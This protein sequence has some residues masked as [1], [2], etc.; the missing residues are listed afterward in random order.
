MTVAR[1][2]LV[3]PARL[4]D[5]APA[6]RPADRGHRRSRAAVALRARARRAAP[7]RGGAERRPRP[8][9][10]PVVVSSRT[11]EPERDRRDRRAVGGRRAGHRRADS[12]IRRAATRLQ[13]VLL[14]AAAE[15]CRRLARSSPVV[16]E[17]RRDARGGVRSE[18]RRPLSVVGAGGRSAQARA[19]G[20]PRY[21]HAGSAHPGGAAPDDGVHRAARAGVVPDRPVPAASARGVPAP[22]G[23]PAP[24]VVS[25]SFRSSRTFTVS[26]RLRGLQ[27]F[28][29]LEGAKR[30]AGRV[31]PRRRG[32]R[33]RGHAG[34]P[35]HRIGRRRTGADDRRAACSRRH[36]AAGECDRSARESN[37]P[38]RRLAW[39]RHRACTS[40]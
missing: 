11:G 4:P 13:C 17:P 23:P 16:P 6:G 18:V 5:R 31:A 2:A 20:H 37:G 27:A 8:R 32:R 30:R 3:L 25:R 9:P 22:G 28:Q 12:R 21:R 39:N 34:S 26:R 7:S 36:C 29:V 33:G 24:D 14:R 15:H 19:A 35:G 10:S 1:E 40:G 38:S